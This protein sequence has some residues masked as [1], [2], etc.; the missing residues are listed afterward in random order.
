MRSVQDLLRDDRWRCALLCALVVL[1]LW[2]GLSDYVSVKWGMRYFWLLL[3]PVIIRVREHG[4]RSLRYLFALVPLIA[5]SAWQPHPVFRFLALF[6]AV[7]LLLES[8]VGK[9]DRHAPLFAV[10]VAPMTN[11]FFNTFGFPVRLGISSAV[12]RTLRLIDPQAMDMGNAILFRGHEFHVDPDCMGLRMITTSLLVTI[13]LVALMERR[14]RV[15]LPGTALPALLLGTFAMVAVSNYVRIIL[16]VITGAPAGGMWHEVLGLISWVTIVLLP[17]ALIVDRWI[18]KRGPSVS[19][20][21]AAQWPVW[22][23]F[24]APASMIPTILVGMAHPVVPLETE[25]DAVAQNLTVA[26]CERTVLDNH[27][28]RFQ[29]ASTL[30]YLKPGKPFYS[31]DHHPMSCWLGSGYHFTHEVIE[32]FRDGTICRGK[33]TNGNDTRYSA[34]WY[35]NGTVQTC[36]Q[37]DWRWRALKGEGPFRLVNVTADSPHDLMREVSR[38]FRALPAAG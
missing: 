37:L 9:L 10:L 19:A 15:S 29:S 5:L 23:R 26:G 35:D 7:F 1:C 38:L 3:L 12:A 2:P 25:Y 34:W 30:I 18:S 11:Y 28:V 14:K 20:N 17:V 22:K 4:T 33:I 13:A 36:G 31:D 24:V 6:A 16:L 21:K 27:L 32:A 8:F